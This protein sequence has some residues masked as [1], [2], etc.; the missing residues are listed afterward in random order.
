MSVPSP[1][2]DAVIAAHHPSDADG[3][4]CATCAFRPGTQANQTVHTI[5]LARLSVEGLREFHCHEHPRLCRGFI[6]ALNLRGVPQDED[7]RRWSE[8]AGHAADLLGDAISAVA[9]S[10]KAARP[11]RAATRE[12]A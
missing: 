1:A 6:A 5:E 9:A 4:P 8:V 2:C 3:G 12:E 10:E 11:P 7:D